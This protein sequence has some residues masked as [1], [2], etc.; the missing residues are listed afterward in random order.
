MNHEFI[1]KIHSNSKV[2][3][4]KTH[5]TPIPNHI[6]PQQR[7]RK[8]VQA[9]NIYK[10]L[11]RIDQSVR[12]E[13]DVVSLFSISESICFRWFLVY[14]FCRSYLVLKKLSWGKWSPNTSHLHTLGPRGPRVP[15]SKGHKVQG[16]QGLRFLKVTFKYELVLILKVLIKSFLNSTLFLY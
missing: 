2:S 5:P 16:S 6:E 11:Y 9:W 4:V 14:L 10:Y 1:K 13:S 3:K 12:G 7:R 15:M 8:E